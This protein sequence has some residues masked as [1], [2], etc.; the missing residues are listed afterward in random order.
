M[1]NAKE[2]LEAGK[3]SEAIQAMNE[4]VKRNPTDLQRRGFLAELLC[5][6]GRLERADAQLEV[7]V[8]QDAKAAL[9]VALMRQLIRAETARR[10]FY[11]SGR[12]PEFLDVPA[13]NLQLYVEASIHARE[14]RPGDAARLLEQ[15]EEQRP[16]VKGTCNGKP[17]SDLR[18][19]DDL[20]AGVFEVLTSTG[21]FYWIPVERVRSIEFRKPER[22]RDLIWRRAL[23]SVASGPDG[24]VFL[25]ATYCP[26]GT[27]GDERA[28][29]GRVT[30]WRGGDG[31]PMRGIGQVCFLIDEES[32]P[33]M[34]MDG[35]TFEERD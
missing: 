6:S 33:I 22:L 20:T 21:K 2:L 18:D 30:D 31:A 25:P 3:L 14:K 12:L 11:A 29:L 4:E 15:A 5:A 19:L 16:R 23:M 8:Q 27:D 7:V 34:Q 17:F 35:V 9:T 1:L 26:D 10:D 32:V 13:S 24:E 28:L